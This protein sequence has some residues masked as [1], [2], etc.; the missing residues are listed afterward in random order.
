MNWSK[1]NEIIQQNQRFALTAHMFP[2]GDAVG[3]EM[4]LYHHLKSLGKEVTVINNQ[5]SYRVHDF[6][7]S[8]GV[9]QLFEENK[10]P[11]ILEN[12]DVI[13]ILDVSTTHYMGR[14]G[15]SVKK[16]KATKICIDHHVR[17]S[18]FVDFD[19]INEG[20]CATGELV[21]DFFKENDLP[22][23][24]EI[25][26]SLY[27]AILTDTGVFRFS[28]TTSKAHMIAADLLTKGIDHNKIYQNLYERTSWSQLNL[29]G[30]GLAKIKSE[31]D[32]KIVWLHL[33]DKMLEEAKATWDDTTGFVDVLRT[34]EGVKVS[35]I[36]RELNDGILKIHF[37]SKDGINIQPLAQEL[38]G[39]GHKVAAGASI[40]GDAQ[41]IIPQ[42]LKKA[43][44]LL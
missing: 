18:E 20:A 27:T 43:K 37:R 25:G 22:I 31:A 41:K 39:G 28:N 23:S 17:D 33:S 34:I 15:Q 26:T 7:D 16:S 12:V 1:V 14:V 9:I 35:I 32:G 3:S 13:F 4:A 40:E 2:D 21:Y 5:P 44:Q 30:A 36:F 38:G 19:Y 29:L 42:V 11:Q 6:L 8:D 10:H 24:P